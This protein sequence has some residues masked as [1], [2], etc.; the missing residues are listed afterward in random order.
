M[1]LNDMVNKI[2]IASDRWRGTPLMAAAKYEHFQIVDYLIKKGADPTIT[3]CYG[4]NALH[5]AAYH[6]NTNTKMIELLLTHM[7]LASINKKNRWGKTPLDY[8]YRNN[9][10]PIRQ[11]IIDLMRSKGAKA[12]WFDER[13]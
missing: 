12:Y 13:G 11:E 3:T 7:P 8:T 1:T 5:V 2:G 10:S 4:D 6:N 9:R